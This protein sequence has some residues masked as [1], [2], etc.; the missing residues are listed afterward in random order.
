MRVRAWL[1]LFV[2]LAVVSGRPGAAAEPQ[3][4]AEAARLNTEGL[5]R[6]DA[7]DFAGAIERFTRARAL[8]PGEDILTLNLAN[9]HAAHGVELADAGDARGAAT[10]FRQ[11]RRLDPENAAAAIGLTNLHYARG[12]YAK[13]RG[14]LDPYATRHP[15]DAEVRKL[16]GEL[17]YRLGD[18]EDAVHHWE[19]AQRLRP[20]DTDLAER[21][22]KVNREREVEA[23]FGH[24]RDRY[25]TVR[26]AEDRLEDASYHVL[27]LCGEARRDI[28]RELRSFPRRPI[29]V[30]LYTT[31]QF[32]AATQQ[33]GH[34][35]GLYDGKIR[36]RIPP[37]VLDPAYLRRVVYHEYAHLVIG[38]LTRN[39]CPYW[40]NEG[41]A[42]WLSEPLTP[43][44]RAHLR[45][46]LRDG[47]LPS[48]A[49]LEEVDIAAASAERLRLV[50]GTA[51]ATVDYLR[52][53]YSSGYLLD[54]LE[55]LG[56][57]A[58][59]EEALRQRYGRTYASLDTAVAAM[60]KE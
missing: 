1:G 52:A 7:G 17:A 47:G 50:N 14:V 29:E 2:A 58:A 15:E 51:F 12:E 55:A 26:Y 53:R 43:D 11:A 18:L 8:L 40:L 13:A 27:R 22:A 24:E 57:G 35:A 6:Y 10:Q 42:Q 33:Q 34:V 56:H 54:L 23:R 31:D 25:F 38:E 46:A 41:L 36:I 45:A 16:L 59:A 21:I 5:A 20:D 44:V 28:G 60:L 39:Q 19:L 49:A 9:A 48:V 30:L 3:P 32:D 4:A 37:G